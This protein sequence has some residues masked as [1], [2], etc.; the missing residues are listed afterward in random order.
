MLNKYKRPK[1]KQS[2]FQIQRE[3]KYILGSNLNKVRTLIQL[4]E[5]LTRALCHF[6]HYDYEVACIKAEMAPL[7]LHIGEWDEAI[8]MMEEAVHGFQYLLEMDD[9]DLVKHELQLVHIYDQVGQY[10]AAIYLLESVMDTIVA[11]NDAE[12]PT[13]Q[14]LNRLLAE[15]LLKSD[16]SFPAIEIFQK[17]LE[18]RNSPDTTLL[19]EH[20]DLA[21]AFRGNGLTSEA[22]RL[23]SD[24][25]EQHGA[26]IEPS[27]LTSEAHWELALNYAELACSEEAL[28]ESELAAPIFKQTYQQISEKEVFFLLFKMKQLLKTGRINQAILC[29]QAAY[30]ASCAFYGFKH[31][32]TTDL[33]DML[34]SWKS[35]EVK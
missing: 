11:S 31:P 27:D 5:Q 9:P 6:G 7:H 21:R 25:L 22:I 33:W 16:N 29:G 8:R 32:C 14:K 15:L 24:A 26:Q 3:W 34:Q 28:I 35:D 12:F 18:N 19:P 20:I 1:R 23:L 17:L 4:E 10:E 2:D 30:Q 13:L